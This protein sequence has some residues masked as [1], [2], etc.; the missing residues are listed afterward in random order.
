MRA[1]PPGTTPPPGFV[2]DVTAK[3][4]AYAE[5]G[6]REFWVLGPGEGTA[7]VLTLDGDDYRTAGRATGW[8]GV[9]WRPPCST[10]SELEAADLFR[11][12]GA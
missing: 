9:A 12:V 8:G 10:G 11:P 3:R 4:L 5:D 1:T 7:E 6:V 2:E